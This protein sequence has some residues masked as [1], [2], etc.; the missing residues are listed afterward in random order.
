MDKLSKHIIRTINSRRQHY[1]INATDLAKRLNISPTALQ[2][3]LRGDRNLQ[4]DEFV[5]LCSY[6]NLDIRDFYPV[7]I[8]IHSSTGPSISEQGSTTN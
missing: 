3:V 1:G 8:G 5:L 2:A 4:A 7:K 6:F